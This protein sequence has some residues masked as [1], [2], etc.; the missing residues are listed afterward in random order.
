MTTNQER[1]YC[2]LTIAF[3]KDTLRLKFH[4]AKFIQIF[5][6]FADNVVKCCN[7]LSTVLSFVKFI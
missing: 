2:L 4:C 6:N 3:H 7:R 1:N 5:G